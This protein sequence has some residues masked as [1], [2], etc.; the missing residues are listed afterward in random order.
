MNEDTKKHA[1]DAYKFMYADKR[2]VKLPEFDGYKDGDI[3]IFENPEHY[4][5]EAA[6]IIVG[7]YASDI[8]HEYAKVKFFGDDNVFTVFFHTFRK[9]T[10]SEILEYKLTGDQNE[11]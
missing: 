10:N 2:P 5:Y 1:I 11:Q 6:A 4:P 3:I 7:I 9:A 8:M